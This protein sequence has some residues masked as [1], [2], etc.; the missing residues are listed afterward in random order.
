MG[1]GAGMVGLLSKRWQAGMTTH[2]S[3]L[4]PSLASSTV[5]ARFAQL[6]RMRDLFWLLVSFQRTSNNI[7]SAC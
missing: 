5:S 1:A 7:I 3:S 4:T 6:Q 2:S